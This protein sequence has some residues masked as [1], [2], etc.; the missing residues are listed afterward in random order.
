MIYPGTSCQNNLSRFIN[1]ATGKYCNPIITN[2]LYGKHLL[3]CSDINAVG[4]S[5]FKLSKNA[6]FWSKQTRFIL[7]VG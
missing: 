7:K 6:V 5:H 4:C 3:I 2:W 1:L